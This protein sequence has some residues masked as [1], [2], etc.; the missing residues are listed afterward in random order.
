MMDYLEFCRSL[1]KK[2]SKALSSDFH[3]AER[4]WKTLYMEEEKLG[5]SSHTTNWKKKIPVEAELI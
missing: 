2:K 5:N 1:L 3:A 4:E